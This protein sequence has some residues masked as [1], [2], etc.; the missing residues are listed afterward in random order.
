MT[1]TSLAHLKRTVRPGQR[2]HVTNNWHPHISGM[3]TI[4]KVQT[5]RLATLAPGKE[6]PWWVDWPKASLARIDGAK[7]TFLDPEDPEKV[8]FVYDFDPA[9]DGES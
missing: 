1:F 7:L 4:A 9:G 2:V 5:N 8:A 3:R 6:Q